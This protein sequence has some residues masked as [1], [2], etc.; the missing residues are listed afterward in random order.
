MVKGNTTTKYKLTLVLVAIISILLSVLGTFGA[1]LWAGWLTPPQ[2]DRQTMVHDMG[3][4]VMPFNLGQTTHIFE[5]TES[6][7]VQQVIADDPNDDDQIALIR[8]HLE[9][10]VERFRSGDFSDPTSLHGSELPGIEELAAG[11][12]QVSIEYAELPAGAEIVFTTQ[13]LQLITAIHRW[14][15]AQLSDHGADAT[16]R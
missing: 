16:Y 2:G 11:L 10:E 13:D 9:Y 7:G 6:G 3:S 1:L 4:G 15:G 12:T 5:M 8:Q 14:F